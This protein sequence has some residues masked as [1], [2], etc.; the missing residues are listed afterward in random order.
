MSD[1]RRL[2]DLVE[3]ET[4]FAVYKAP[5]PVEHSGKKVF[6]AGSI[7]M[8]KAVDWQAELTSALTDLP[9]AV[10][11][12]RRD[13]W[14]STWVQDISNEKFNEQVT[15]ELEHLE[16]AD[17]IAVYFDP[18]GQAPITLMELGLHAQSGKCVVCCPEGYWR[19][20]NVQMV[21]D[22]YDVP[23]VETIEELIDGVRKLLS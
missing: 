11:N 9:I 8:G 4:K 2:I 1:F 14:D 3:G 18:K 23:L 6:L 13:D 5:Q 22:R 15:W 20:G 19:R 21:C 16:A 17:V 10:M 7:D 12:P